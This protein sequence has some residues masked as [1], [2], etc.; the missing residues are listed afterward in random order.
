[1]RAIIL[2]G[3]VGSRLYPLTEISNKQLQ[4]VFDKPMIYYPLTVLIAAGIRE[5]CVITSKGEV[6]KFSQLLGNG[7]RWGIKIDYLQQDHPAGI[8]HAFVI[9]EDYIGDQNVV[10]MLGDNIFSGSAD[11]T[12]ALSDFSRGATI[13]AYRVK[14]PHLYG[15]IEF[16]G[17]GKP[18]SIVEKP[19]KPKS[20]FVIP[21]IYI[22]DNQVVKIAKNLVPSK[23]G[24]LEIS[25][26]N[27]EYLREGRLEVRR[28]SRGFVWLDAGTSSSRHDASSYVAT[29]ERRQGV[30]IGCP[31]EA[32]LHRGFL[33]LKQFKIL[34][35]QMPACEYKNYLRFVAQEW[36]LDVKNHDA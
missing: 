11:F 24:E 8:A 16:D 17:S 36:S 34:T 32:A 1:M 19:L 15:V 9:A 28:L 3:G 13:F 5:I 7:C 31:E 2:A 22:Y 14:D 27:L 10:L 18:V 25:D 21:G 30:K 23:R 4:P 6:D 26:V 20:N 12:S 29:I 33:D 35:E